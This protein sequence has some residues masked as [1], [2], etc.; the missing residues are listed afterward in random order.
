MLLM[1]LTGTVN[2][3]PPPPSHPAYTLLCKYISNSFCN[4]AVLSV[5]YN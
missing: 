1:G 4:M 3:V 5:K 2:K